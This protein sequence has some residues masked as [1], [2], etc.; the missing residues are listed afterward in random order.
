[1]HCLGNT[2]VS[3]HDVT[4]TLWWNLCVGA[5]SSVQK[6]TEIWLIMC[7]VFVVC[8]CSL[9]IEKVDWKKESKKSGTAPILWL[10]FTEKKCVVDVKINWAEIKQLSPEPSVIIS[11][12]DD[13]VILCQQK[14]L[15]YTS[16]MNILQQVRHKKFNVSV[17]L[18]EG[19]VGSFPDLNWSDMCHQLTPGVGPRPTIGL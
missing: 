6:M 11:L 14:N 10:T 8:C 2:K 13:L 15:G 9:G 17:K 12:M 16:V 3:K 4:L 18:G 5:S 7:S 1:M 19:Y